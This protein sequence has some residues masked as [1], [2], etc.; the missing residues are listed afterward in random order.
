MPL[1]DRDGG[2][3]GAPSRK[4]HRARSRPSDPNSDPYRRD[5][6]PRRLRA[7]HRHCALPAKRSARDHPRVGRC[8]NCSRPVY[9][10]LSVKFIALAVNR[11]FRCTPEPIIHPVPTTALLWEAQHDRRCRRTT[12]EDFAEGRIPKPQALGLCGRPQATV[13][14]SW[15]DPVIKDASEGWR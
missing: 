3:P 5:G 4:E 13:A 10:T 15:P 1:P 8:H 7:H 12:G 6:H 2:S 14:T 11:P 9:D